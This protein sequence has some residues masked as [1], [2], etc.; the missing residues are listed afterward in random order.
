MTQNEV[1]SHLAEGQICGWQNVQRT[2]SH[3][4]GLAPLLSLVSA[5]SMCGSRCHVEWSVDSSQLSPSP[6]VP[7]APLALAPSM[8][9]RVCRGGCLWQTAGC[10]TAP[11]DQSPPVS[12]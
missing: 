8:L 12:Y 5:A 6:W 10:S 9:Q 11:R 7:R 2:S 1:C 3:A 4:E